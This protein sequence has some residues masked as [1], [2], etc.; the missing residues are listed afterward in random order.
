M[1]KQSA[2]DEMLALLQRLREANIAYALGHHRD[3]AIMI[4]VTVPGERWEIE[5]VD[6][7]DEVQIEVERFA[8]DGAIRDELSLDE[9]FEKH[10]SSAAE[11]PQAS[12]K[13]LLAKQVLQ[14]LNSGERASKKHRIGR[15]RP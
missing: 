2:F 13:P 1:N 4:A 6:Y 15:R 12:N 5:F 11:E 9:L 7:D 10:A 3:D 8:S 14:E